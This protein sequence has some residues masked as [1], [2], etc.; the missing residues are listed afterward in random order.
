MPV[1]KSSRQIKQE[2]YDLQHAKSFMRVLK[3]HSL[4]PSM[5][6]Q[7]TE[8][9]KI[10]AKDYAIDVDATVKRTI[11]DWKR[12]RRSVAPRAP[13]ETSELDTTDVEPSERSAGQLRKSGNSAT[14]GAHQ[15][16]SRAQK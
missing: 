6:R 10:R 3:M 16:K 12:E 2:K 15:I 8:P 7:A 11:D 5:L 4:M 9:P 1:Y 14:A 13:S